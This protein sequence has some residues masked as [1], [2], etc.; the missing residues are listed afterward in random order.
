MSKAKYIAGLVTSSGIIV[1]S[2]LSSNIAVSSSSNAAFNTANTAVNNAASAS[3][4]ANTGITL[5]QAAF[6]AQN[7]T[8]IIAN[9]KFNTS[10]GTI[11]GS[12]T[13]NTDL[14]VSGNL[15]ISGNTVTV[16]SSNM[17][18][19]DPLIYM[20]QGNPSNLNDIGLVG[21]FTSDHYQ[22]TG[23][24]RDHT[25]GVWKFFSNVS[26]EPSTTVNFSEAN[27]VYDSIKVGGLT[28]SNGTANGVT[29]LNASKV[30][31]TGSGLVFDGTN[32]GIGTSSPSYKLDV[33][34]G[35]R[36]NA[37]SGGYLNLSYNGTVA[38]NLVAGNGVF[39]VNTQ[40]TNTVINPNGGNL[41]LGVTPSAWGG[42]W[43]AAS[44]RRAS[45][46][47]S[48]DS[49]N[50]FVAFNTYFDGT[51]W[52]YIGSD[53]ASYYQQGGG[54][55]VHVW[56]IAP[57]GTADNAISFTQAMTLQASGGLSLGT[58]SDPGS[59][60]FLLDGFTNGVKGIYFRPGFYTEAQPSITTYDHSGAANDGLRIGAYD[61]ISF[62]IGANVAGEKMRI[63]SSGK[64]GIGV[65]SPTTSLHVNSSN[66]A[67]IFQTDGVVYTMLGKKIQSFSNATASTLLSFV[68][69]GN[70]GYMIKVVVRGTSAVA[71][72]MWEDTFYAWWRWLS[73]SGYAGSGVS[74]ATTVNVVGTHTTGTLSWLTPSTA[75]ALQ[76]TQGAN[77]YITESV[78][79]FVTCRDVAYGFTFN[80][81]AVNFG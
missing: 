66:A 58:T 48:S 34:G 23:I 30:L 47:A 6:N 33:V 25:D 45:L 61:G 65:T 54:S 40:T 81:N 76:Y 19:A 29:Y 59:G 77:G 27:T 41:G 74:S 79:V 12:V 53:F 24:V 43:L 5:A 46:A 10:G 64:V 50:A 75:P 1:D 71:S 17:N 37:T 63:D 72:T 9:T 42:S 68:T 70:T 49:R 11:T 15:Y 13:I 28:L 4:Y 39:Y 21:H 78:D 55:G 35:Q 57:S 56:S 26:T 38:G 52:R 18:I 36:I 22:H 16:D 80:P 31:T 62:Y 44:V 51:N 20:A 73:G 60:N 8:A 3:L 2:T 14:S 69:G 7:S 67:V 32:L